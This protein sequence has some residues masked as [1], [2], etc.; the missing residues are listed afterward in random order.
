[1][2][3][4]TTIVLLG[5]KTRRNLEETRDLLLGLIF[6]TRLEI[7]RWFVLYAQELVFVL[8]GVVNVSFILDVE[9][10]VDEMDVMFWVKT[11]LKLI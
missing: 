10:C 3:A 9:S 7:C 2:E 6:A 11:S 5:P 8:F 1:M 4:E